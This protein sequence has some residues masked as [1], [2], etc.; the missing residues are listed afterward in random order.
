MRFVEGIRLALAQIRQE[1]LKSAFSLLGVI[2][3][4]VFLIIVVSVVEGVDRYI[5]E[6]LSG[7]IFGVN[8]IQVRRV[9]QVQIE[10]DPS[11][12]REWAR[13]PR[14]THDDAAAIRDGLSV[15]ALVGVESNASA[16]IRSPEGRGAQGVRVLLASHDVLEIRDLVVENGRPFSPQEADRGIPVA[17]LG[18][19]V[20]DALFPDSDPVEQR[21]R[22][23]D[24]P[25]RIVGVLEEQGSLL[26]QSMDNL[27]VVPA[28]S[29]AT[30]FLGRP[31]NVSGVVIQTLAPGDL[32]IARADAEAA[33]RVHRRLRPEVPSNFELETADDSLAFWDRISTVL[34]V[35]LPG[36]V[37]I[38][39][40]VGG[41]VIM[42]IMLV[43][44]MQRTRE[45]G[46]RMA[47]GAKRSDIL[48]Q[49]LIEA[50]TL[51][52]AGAV[53]GVLIGL[54]VTG[55]V[56]S[57]TPLP[58]AVAPIWII[59]GV[60]LGMSVGII[61]GVYP[62]LRASRLDPVDALRYE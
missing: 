5:T 61:A 7:Q 53:V 14:L 59:L 57:S 47:L 39:L 58:A 8:T 22:I 37:S 17:I 35:A 20:A 16:E 24:F 12:T 1:K 11:Q 62:A 40:V 13:R 31:R 52:G 28:R 54:G 60:V 21:V 19:S 15:P 9:P 26:G 50:T 34:F 45:I 49:F 42:N 3:G 46:V 32:E 30:R 38:S 56:R 18:V 23:N 41:I 27:V 48:T 10:V 43:S 33:L 55:I 51:S 44:V 4:V 36:L 6:D 29:P 2:I 25:F